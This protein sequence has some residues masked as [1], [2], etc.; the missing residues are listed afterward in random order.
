[1]FVNRRMVGMLIIFW[2]KIRRL[3]TVEHWSHHWKA[4]WERHHTPSFTNDKFKSRMA[5]LMVAICTIIKRSVNVEG[6]DY[7]PTWI[8]KNR[9]RL[10][11][12]ITERLEYRIQVAGNYND[13]G[14]R[15]SNAR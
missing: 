13:L 6:S 7:L 14:E 12:E 10:C 8:G 2:L 4:F 9:L 11:D 15:L 5:L 1:M 3:C